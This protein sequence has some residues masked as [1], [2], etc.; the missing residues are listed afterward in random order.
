M[1]YP[2]LYTFWIWWARFCGVIGIAVMA[3]FAIVYPQKNGV[4]WTGTNLQVL[5]PVIKPQGPLRFVL[6][7]E[8]QKSCPGTVVTTMSSRPG[9]GPAATVAFRRPVIHPGVSKKSLLIDMVLSDSVFPGH[10]DVVVT[11]NSRCP[12]N[13]QIDEVASFFVEVK[14]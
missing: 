4:V 3:T 14:P 7:V 11:V 5:T 12:L 6:D 1:K 10:W 8:A 2:W 9:A 13:A